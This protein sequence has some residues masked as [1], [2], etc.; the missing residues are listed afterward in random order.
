MKEII[1]SL[2][3]LNNYKYSTISGL[4]EGE[5]Y[6][7]PFVLNQKIAIVTSLYNIDGYKEQL[8]SLGKKVLIFEDKI[9]LLYGYREKNSDIFKKYYIN[10]SKLA[11]EDFDILLLTPESL[12]QKLPSKSF[13]L[14]NSLKFV[15]NGD[16]I[17]EKLVS[18]IVD[19][20]YKKQDFVFAPGEFAVRGDILDIFP[21]NLNNPIRLNFFDTNLEQINTFDKNS[22]KIIEELNEV[23]VCLNTFLNFFNLNKDE[24]KKEVNLSVQKLNLSPESMLRI[25]NITATQFEYL[26]QNLE[27]ISS[28]FYLPFCK[29]FTASFFDY[30][31]DA[32]FFIDEPKL[33]FDKLTQIE[34]ENM[35]SYLD[36]SY[37]GELL[38]K[39]MEFYL[40]KKHILKNIKN[41]SLIA[42]S[43]LLTQNKIFNNEYCLY[44]SCLKNEKYQN[45]FLNLVEDVKTYIKNG[46]TLFL[47]CGLELTLKKVK[48]FFKQANIKFNEVQ[49]IFNLKENSIN[50]SIQNVPYS[51]NFQTEKFVLIGSLA[52]NN[53]QV[54]EVNLKKEDSKPKF[55]PQVGE[56]VVH[57]VHGIGKCVGIK[58]LKITSVNRDYIIVE[59]LGGDLLYLPCEN[60]DMLSSFIGEGE[61][62]CNKIGGAEFSRVKQKVKNSI[63][64]MAFNLINV[65]S[66]RLNSKGFK[67][68]PDSYLQKEF[69]NAFVY[70]YTND[71]ITAINDIKKDMESGKIMDRLVCGD[72]G[73]GKTEVA[74]TVAFKAIQDGKQVAIICP[75]TILCEQ[76]Y[77]TALSRMKNFMVEVETINRFKTKKEQTEI[78]NK[79]EQGKIDLICGTHRLFSKDVKFKDLGLIILDEEQRFGVED[80]EKLKNIKKTVDVIS[81]SATPIPRTLYMS[82]VG[83]RDVSFLSTA[84]KDRK[85][86]QTSVIEYSDNL[87]VDCCKRE[88]D[89][90][91][92]VLIVYNKVE[93]ITKFYAHVKNLLPN[94]KIGFAHGQMSS[95][96]LENAIFDLYSG[97]TQILISTVLIENGI[98]L[99]NANTLFVIDADKLGL[100]QLYQLRGR[101]GRS[102]IEAYAYFSFAKNK[103]L[104]PDSYKRLDAIMEFSDFGGGY[105][106]A[107]RDLEIRGAGDVLGKL[108]HGHM[109]QIGYEMYVKLLNEAVL[110]LNGKTQEELVETKIDISLNAYLPNNYISTNENRIVFYTKVS[111]INSEKELNSLLEETKL[112]YGNLPK[113]V[114]QLCK[115][116]LIKNLAQ[117]LFIKNI[118]LDEFNCKITFYKEVLEKNL[119]EI[120][121]KPSVY[122]VLTFENLPIITLL[123][124]STIE[125]AEQNLINFLIN[126]NQEIKNK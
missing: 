46:Y 100:S 114:E 28:V 25:S 87:L 92:Q 117:K 89:R 37:K 96:E 77:N 39:S 36:L 41:F 66:S 121:K 27:D 50:I 116:G 101:I 123:K 63:K 102:N 67:F 35:S 93:S 26:D 20:G 15:K 30:L 16:Y 75:T 61:P 44:F 1:K 104:T 38:P 11:K 19:M 88:L 78:L 72:V 107:M 65:Y 84:P 13:I 99:P 109:Q 4:N 40:E 14:E 62:K 34:D 118:K 83:I 70:P 45:K 122:Y 18:K 95:K 80:K 3:K 21:V 47:S 103:M 23:E 55:L 124:Q 94:V 5:K 76:H 64:E 52:L 7:L 31:Q 97:K 74:L 24:I 42:Y 111:K 58:N 33:I 6:F 81:L 69:E 110:E 10:T 113:P 32:K 57:Q 59:Y 60:V 120:L 2:Q 56:Y 17:L 108:Q 9:P 106:I 68:S 51:A 98:D 73:F 85:K 82:L 112:K 125:K 71:Q 86:I 8:E 105:K 43:R 91:G 79:L 22:F 49:N 126:L 12:F 119:F 48:D 115:V 53:Q 54:L 29:Y 90:N